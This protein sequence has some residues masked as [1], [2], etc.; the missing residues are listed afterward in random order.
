M[1]SPIV[2]PDKKIARV[3]N[4]QVISPSA[5][6]PSFCASDSAQSVHGAVAVA[7]EEVL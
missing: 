6:F 3:E 1:S 2:S 5:T 4:L 7:V